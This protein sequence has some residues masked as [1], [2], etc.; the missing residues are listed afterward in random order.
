M[1]RNVITCDLCEEELTRKDGHSLHIEAKRRWR[2]RSDEPRDYKTDVCDDCYSFI[3]GLR[4]C[5]GRLN[6]F[7][8]VYELRQAMCTADHQ[9]FDDMLWKMA[10]DC[11]R[12]FEQHK[13]IG[14]K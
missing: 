6:I 11:D 9:K 8:A 14:S 3:Q 10:K 1:E 4:D 12:Y 2:C 7:R 13:N 5:K